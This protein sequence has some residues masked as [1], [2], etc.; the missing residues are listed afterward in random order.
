MD[1][2]QEDITIGEVQ[3]TI[4]C[5]HIVGLQSVLT[6]RLA[7]LCQELIPSLIGFEVELS[8]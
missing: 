4:Q 6:K 2:L 1:L 3:Y 5:S 8:C 7:I